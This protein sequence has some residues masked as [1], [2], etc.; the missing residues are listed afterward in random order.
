M[1]SIADPL[2]RLLSRV[3]AVVQST[4][5]VVPPA[6]REVRWCDAEF[7]WGS[8]ALAGLTVQALSEVPFCLGRRGGF[9]CSPSGVSS[10]AFG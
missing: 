9:L 6:R 5:V 10:Y 4:H 2:A 7:G 3:V 8:E 1:G